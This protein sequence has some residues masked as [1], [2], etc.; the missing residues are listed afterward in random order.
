M[1]PVEDKRPCSKTC[2]KCLHRINT[3]QE[4]QKVEPQDGVVVLHP[5]TSTQR[6][7]QTAIQRETCG[8]LLPFSQ[9]RNIFTHFNFSSSPKL[10]CIE[11]ELTPTVC[12]NIHSFSVEWESWEA[13]VNYRELR[14]GVCGG[15]R[16]S[17]WSEMVL[18]PSA[19][20]K[21]CPLMPRLRKG[22]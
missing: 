10:T 14:G 13:G 3:N 2:N 18:T 6:T 16:H 9:F 20:G 19:S 4:E 15:V 12:A 22:E 8:G 7:Q 1:G 21:G 11:M 17:V 5:N